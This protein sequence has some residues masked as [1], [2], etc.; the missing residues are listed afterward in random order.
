MFKTAIPPSG[1]NTREF[2]KKRAKKPSPFFNTVRQN[3]IILIDSYFQ[4]ALSFHS[5][6]RKREQKAT[7]FFTGLDKGQWS[8]ELNKLIDS[9]ELN[10]DRSQFNLIMKKVNGFVGSIT[11]NPYDISYAPIDGGDL[12][13]SE[14]MKG[15]IVGEREKTGWNDVINLALRYGIIHNAYTRFKITKKYSIFGNIGMDFIKSSHVLTDPNWTTD[16]L[17]DCDWLITSTYLTP[18]QAIDRYPEKASL[19]KKRVIDMAVAQ[20]AG[21]PENMK[22]SLDVTMDEVYNNMCRFIE[23][24]HMVSEKV[25]RR[26]A[27]DENG[28]SV[29]IP[30]PPQ[31][32]SESEAGEEWLSAWYAANGVEPESI[33]EIEDSIRQYYV[34]TICPALSTTE[35]FEDDLSPIQCGRLPYYNFTFLRH[36]GRNIGFVDILMDPQMNFNKRMN[37]INEI[38]G[39]SAKDALL[40]DPLAF[41][42]DGRKI[43]RVKKNINKPGFVE[44][45]APGFLQAGG[46]AFAQV[47][48]APYPQLEIYET[49]KYQQMIDTITPQTVTADGR[50]ESSKETGILF[51][52]KRSQIYETTS[53]VF[54]QISTRYREIAESF[55]FIAR[56]HKSNMYSTVT[57]NKGS[58]NEDIVEINKKEMDETGEV[59]TINDV[60][61]IPFQA[62]SIL[63]STKGSTMRSVARSSIIDIL[64]NMPLDAQNMRMELG[65]MYF[66]KSDEFSPDDL[67]R[68]KGA[69]GLDKQLVNSTTYFQVK[70]AQSQ[71]QQLDAQTQQMLMQQQ[72]AAPGQP[73]PPQG[74][75]Q[76]EQQQQAV[77]Q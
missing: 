22:I 69:I 1:Y 42:Q 24:H 65:M 48:K 30:T 40:F 47:P 31:E 8:S 34:T 54:D 12:Q 73:G 55:F 14:I 39:K 76:P 25:T 16:S 27:F 32:F 59:S 19:I 63:K 41:G 52:K 10:M 28:N 49:D 17:E 36:D 2:G 74:Q 72:G 37:L 51:E 58:E 4:S 46:Q 66:D 68:I 77:Q 61:Q 13:S 21:T 62:V 67:D 75:P 26:V 5:V 70:Q 18:L 57:V 38:L 3:P 23:F 45:T 6:D 56:D 35:V 15:L 33:I 71:T 53:F 44:A 20:Y 43:D 9:G 29:E 50:N 11:N 7:S 64:G 60:S